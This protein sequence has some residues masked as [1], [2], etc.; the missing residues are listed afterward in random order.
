MADI[1]TREKI[2]IQVTFGV[3][4]FAVEWKKDDSNK[5]FAHEF[6]IMLGRFGIE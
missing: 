4:E 3:P 1:T 5:S 2:V 6:L